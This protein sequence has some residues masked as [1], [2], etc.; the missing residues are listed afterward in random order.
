MGHDRSM[1]ASIRGTDGKYKRIS[2]KKLPDPGA[3]MGITE[4]A[5][6]A[7]PNFWT[8]ET[9]AYG[10]NCQ[11]AVYAYEMNRRGYN[12]EALPADLEAQS[13]GLGNDW[14]KVFVGTKFQSLSIP[15]GKALRES[16][17]FDKDN[18]MAVYRD[19]VSRAIETKLASFGD[20]ARAVLEYHYSGEGS[21][22]PKTGARYGHVIVVE[23]SQ[24]KVH[25]IE[26]QLGAVG[27][28]V[29]SNTLRDSRPGSIRIARIDN[30]EP[31]NLILDC[32]KF[33]EQ[34]KRGK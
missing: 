9:G 22:D 4:A 34:K 17:S 21:K 8:D 28:R 11:R 14:R 18:P 5:D 30:L 10:A 33:K 29:K 16:P 32:V 15:K 12:V 25:Y 6:K 20:G 27:D 26:P 13:G 24:G 1:T 19:A 31:S 7:N 23:Y 3:P 2:S